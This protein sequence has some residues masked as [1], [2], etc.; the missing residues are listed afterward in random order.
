MQKL[1]KE[2][3]QIHE[4]DFIRD[5]DTM[6]ATAS[7]LRTLQR[8][9]EIIEIQDSRVSY[10]FISNGTHVLFARSLQFLT[11][12]FKLRA[13]KQI[14]LLSEKRFRSIHRKIVL[15]AFLRN[16]GQNHFEFDLHSS[17]S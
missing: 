10:R 15:S 17:T 7:I 13:V 5:G 6:V 1:L 14:S 8:E 2:S 11:S 16:D 4:A 3:E 9:L 12:H